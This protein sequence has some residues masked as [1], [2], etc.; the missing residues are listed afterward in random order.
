MNDSRPQ[1]IV[2]ILSCS[3]LEQAWD[4]VLFLMG[5]YGAALTVA[6]VKPV[7]WLLT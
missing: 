7:I 2:N 1:K 3:H 4:P 5:R 6:A